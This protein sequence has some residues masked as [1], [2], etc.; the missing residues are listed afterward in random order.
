MNHLKTSPERKIGKNKLKAKVLIACEDTK[1]AKT[2]LK[3]LAKDYGVL[4][5]VIFAKH[6]GTD[7]MSVYMDIANHIKLNSDVKYES[8]WIVIDR[9]SWPLDKFKGAISAAKSK[10]VYVAYSNEAYELWLLLHYKKQ[11]ASIN[12]NRLKSELSKKDYL[13]DYEKGDEL[14]YEK[15]IQ[16]QDDAIKNAQELLRQ[17]MHNNGAISPDSNNPSTTFHCLVLPKKYW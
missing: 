7:P 13:P 1:S 15:T 9:D 2:Y 5:D 10:G 8:K 6:T 4:A 17:H 3:K 14:V 11:T 16:Y 12:R